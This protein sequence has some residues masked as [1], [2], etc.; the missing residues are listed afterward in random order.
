MVA[1]Q[2]QAMGLNLMEVSQLSNSPA[3]LYELYCLSDPVSIHGQ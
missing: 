1:I 2:N 3:A